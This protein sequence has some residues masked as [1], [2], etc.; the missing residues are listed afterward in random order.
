VDLRGHNTFR[1]SARQH[2]LANMQAFITKNRTISNDVCT[3]L[4]VD[5]ILTTAYKFSHKNHTY[6]IF[7]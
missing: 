6:C 2:F 4:K 1:H 3:S 5:D 7:D